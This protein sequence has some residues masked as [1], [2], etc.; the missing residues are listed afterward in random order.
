MNECSY[1]GPCLTPLIFDSIL[2]FRLN[3]VALV[4]DI[5]SAY[6]QISV[7]PP[8]RDLLRFLW[9][10][11]VAGNDFSI[12]KLRFTRLIYG[13][14][15]SQYLLNAVIRKH[16]AKYRSVDPNFEKTVNDGFYVDDLSTSVSSSKDG[17]DF[18]C[19]EVEVK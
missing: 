10:A 5:A 16:A 9:F 18:Y 14:A 11:D 7:A 17:I 12:K 19:T 2:R 8:Q 4:A 1:K 3:N 6:L 15:P 13:A